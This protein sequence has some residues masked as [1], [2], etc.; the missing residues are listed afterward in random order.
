[1]NLFELR[2]EN[3][4]LSKT[5]TAGLLEAYLHKAYKHGGN[6]CLLK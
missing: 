5:M 3:T 6:K 2:G 1:M 4:A